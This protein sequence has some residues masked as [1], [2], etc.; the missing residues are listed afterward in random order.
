[1][2]IR[3]RVGVPVLEFASSDLQGAVDSLKAATG[4]VAPLID[5]ALLKAH[6]GFIAAAGA[7]TVVNAST[8]VHSLDEVSVDEARVVVHGDG[9]GATATLDVRDA[10]DSTTLCSVT[11]PAAA[12]VAIGPWTRVS[13]RSGDR[14]I[15]VRV[16]GDGV[17]T[18][19]LNSVHLHLR[20]VRFQ[21]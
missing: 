3:S 12:G 14:T 19:T 11:I 1:M 17:H 15:Q 20:T 4:H 21:P 2:S 13:P 5:I 6:A 16:V 10:T 18:Q 8:N 7:G 9:G